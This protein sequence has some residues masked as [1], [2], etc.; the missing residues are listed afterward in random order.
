LQRVARDSKL[1]AA[2]DLAEDERFAP[3]LRRAFAAADCASLLAVPVAVG[4]AEEGGVVLVFFAER[5]SFND[6]ELELARQLGGTAK[7]ALER[8]ELFETERRQRALSQ[9]L[10][11]IATMLTGELD[12]TAIL[13]EVAEQAP[14]LLRADAS[15]IS[16]LDGEE[17]VVRAAAGG[18]VEALE[19]RFSAA[20]LPAAEVLEAQAPASLAD[21]AADGARLGRSEP[22]LDSGYSAYLG[23]PLRGPSGEFHA[24]LAVYGREPRSWRPDEADALNALAASAVGA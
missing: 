6:D 23:V 8:S 1:L 11:R 10:A 9:Q 24:V 19:R 21:A 18:G 4:R 20:L 13:D 17:L 7:G 5:R 2:E 14:L 15:T 22:M 16:V 3:E 12:P